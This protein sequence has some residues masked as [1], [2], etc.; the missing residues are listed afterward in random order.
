MKNLLILV[1]FILFSAHSFGAV[2][3]TCRNGQFISG[4]DDLP[5][6][7]PINFSIVVNRNMNNYS[8]KIMVDG[9]QAPTEKQID[10][11]YTTSKHE[12]ER[13]KSILKI[14]KLPTAKAVAVTTYDF[15]PF[16][17]R[18]DGA[19]ITLSVVVD[20]YGNVLG[21]VFTLGWGVGICK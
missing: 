20:N 10:V 11:R 6:L 14:A 7:E 2:V 19:G 3:E 5:H 12:L 1:A 9:K 8:A 18:D 4:T 16:A 13:V 17:N 15:H 21:K